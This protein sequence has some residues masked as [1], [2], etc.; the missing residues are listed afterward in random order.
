MPYVEHDEIKTFYEVEGDGPPLVLIHGFTGNHEDWR[1][2][3][4]VDALKEA[5]RVI[6]IDMRGHG[7]SEKPLHPDDYLLETLVGDVTAVLDDLKIKTAHI[8]GYA[9][10]GYVAYGFVRYAPKRLRSVIVG[11]MHPYM[12]EEDESHL[13]D[14]VWL[15]GVIELLMEGIEAYVEAYNED[16]PLSPD[17]MERMLILDP[18]ALIALRRA[19]I[20]RWPYLD[21]VPPAMPVPCLVYVGQ[22]DDWSAE[23]AQYA[24]EQMPDGRFVELPDLDHYGAQIRSDMIIPHIIEFLAEVETND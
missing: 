9:I 15:D 8:W 7:D 11:G 22:H 3:G 17:E 24:V 13:D 4:F 21:D 6:L 1:E 20:A 23:G 18:E 16:I 2:F 19:I 12:G 10:G 5:Y 14:D